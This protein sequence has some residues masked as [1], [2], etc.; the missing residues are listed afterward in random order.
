M[1]RG[2]CGHSLQLVLL[3]SD[4]KVLQSLRVILSTAEARE[5][6]VEQG[7]ADLAS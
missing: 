7:E 4:L 1:Q 2:Q 6:F 3:R 5:A